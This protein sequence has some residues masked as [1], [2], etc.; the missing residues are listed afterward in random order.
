MKKNTKN[1]KIFGWCFENKKT[2]E[3]EPYEQYNGGYGIYPTK[4]DLM[5]NV[6]N[7]PQDGYKPVR[8]EIR[9]IK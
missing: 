1:K 6:W 3:L 8:V 7:E 5:K 9:L 2:K 4:Q